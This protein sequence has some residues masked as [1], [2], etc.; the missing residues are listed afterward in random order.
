MTT[1]QTADDPTLAGVNAFPSKI[2]SIAT[3]SG[4]TTRKQR[5][6]LIVG[7]FR[8]DGPT[9]DGIGTQRRYTRVAGDVA[10]LDVDRLAAAEPG[11]ARHAPQIGDG[12]QRRFRDERHRPDAVRAREHRQDRQRAVPRLQ[13]RRGGRRPCC[14][15]PG[16]AGPARHGAPGRAARASTTTSRP[17]TAP[18]TS[19]CR[20]RRCSSS[21]SRVPAH[22]TPPGASPITHSS[23]RPRRRASGWYAGRSRSRSLRRTR[24]AT[25]STARPELDYTAP[26]TVTG[27]GVHFVACDARR[28]ARRTH[29]RSASTRAGRSRRSRARRARRTSNGWYVFP[30]NVQVSA[31]DPGGSDVAQLRC[32]LDPAVAPPTLFSQ[33]PASCPYAGAGA[34]VSTDGVHKVYAAAIDGAGNAGAGGLRHDPVRQHVAGDDDG[35]ARSVPDRA[36]ASARRGP[37]LTLRSGVKNFDIRYRQAAS[38][39]STFGGYTAWQSAT[40]ALTAV[41]TGTAGPTT[42]FS[43]RARDNAGWVAAAYSAEV[44]H[45]DAARRLG[46]DS[47][48]HLVDGERGRPVRRQRLAVD[49]RGGDADVADDGRQADRRARDEAIRRRHDPAPLERQHA[50]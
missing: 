16:P 49:E 39:S 28:W 43:G 48:R 37:G 15:P 46:A 47:C 27:D 30:V 21:R 45:D 34:Y 20:A 25:A 42:C 26:F 7:L 35:R 41:F 36:A 13:R 1:D 22:V 9:L 4:L 33:L 6:N 10:L 38:N 17:P 29:R 8:S 3:F 19:P 14:R 40:P 12:R 18:A 32:V 2:Q 44:V 24:S 5:L 23:A 11:R 50:W 31:L